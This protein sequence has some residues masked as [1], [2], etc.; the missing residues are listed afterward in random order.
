MQSL[1]RKAGD[2]LRSGYTAQVNTWRCNDGSI[3]SYSIWRNYDSIG[4]TGLS[5]Y[6]IRDF[7]QAK[8]YQ[9]IS[10]HDDIISSGLLFLSHNQRT[11]GSFE[12][13][14]R[15]EDKSLQGNT[16]QSPVTLT[17]FVLLAFQAANQNQFLSL[18]NNRQIPNI[19]N[20]GVNYILDQSRAKQFNPYENALVAYVLSELKIPQVNKY[21]DSIENTAQT[22][23][24]LG[25]KYWNGTFD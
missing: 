23:A 20:D 5:A 18:R 25:L 3:G 6:A 16:A 14:G 9:N 22:N 24:L 12:E 2:F 10:I 11:D 15:V 1:S 4:S 19:I 17:A 7:L 13:N 8:R 21:L